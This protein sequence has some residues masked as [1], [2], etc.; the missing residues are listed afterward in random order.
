MSFNPQS[1]DPADPSPLAV[2]IDASVQHL[3]E[4]VD[5]SGGPETNPMATQGVGSQQALMVLRPMLRAW[6]T[7][8]AAAA[9]QAL[10]VMHLETGALLDKHADE[11]VDDLAP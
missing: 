7:E 2:D 8:D 11:D 5:L 1:A 10:A 4:Q 6:A 9:K 3:A